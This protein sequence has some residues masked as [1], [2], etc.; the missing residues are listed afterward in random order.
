MWTSEPRIDSQIFAT[1]R[2][3]R[4]GRM[5]VVSEQSAADIKRRKAREALTWPLRELTANLL[6]IA[7]GAG[8]PLNLAK[9]LAACSTAIQAY[10]ETHNALPSEQEIHGILDCDRSWEQYRRIQKH[11]AEM[12]DILGEDYDEGTSERDRAERLIRKGALQVAASKLL[13]QIP[14]AA[15]GEHGIYEGIRLM[16][17]ARAKSPGRRR[18]KKELRETLEKLLN[19]KTGKRRRKKLPAPPSESLL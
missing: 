15:S 7:N 4:E 2:L 12:K 5:R 6:R 16:E 9:Q 1:F 3:K 19:N 13:S 17:V 18:G 14:Q 10:A 8:R 11:R